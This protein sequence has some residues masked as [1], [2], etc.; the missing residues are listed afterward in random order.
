MI[1]DW[2][3]LNRDF[4]VKIQHIGVFLLVKKCRLRVR[5]DRSHSRRPSVDFNMLYVTNLIFQ[6]YI[7]KLHVFIDFDF[8]VVKPLFYFKT[9]Y[10]SQHLLLRDKSRSARKSS[11][12]VP[13]SVR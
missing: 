1:F 6:S 8:V 10:E 11:H 12:D 7:G 5:T 4:K 3:I 9:N 13:V 2:S